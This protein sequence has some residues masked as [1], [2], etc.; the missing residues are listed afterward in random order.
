M[1]VKFIKALGIIII[2]VV[3]YCVMW[4]FHFFTNRDMKTTWK[5]ETDTYYYEEDPEDG[6]IVKIIGKGGD[7][8]LRQTLRKKIK[9]IY[10]KNG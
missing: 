2:E 3:H 4:F 9:K 5:L 10:E 7:Y 6:R 1:L 8:T